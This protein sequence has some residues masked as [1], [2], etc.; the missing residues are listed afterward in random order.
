MLE[1]FGLADSGK[2]IAHGRFD[3]GQVLA[4]VGM[5]NFRSVLARKA[6]FLTELVERLRFSMASVGVPE[7][8]DQA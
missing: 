7:G 6:H 3:I 4:E 1:R 8:G 2:R 5:K